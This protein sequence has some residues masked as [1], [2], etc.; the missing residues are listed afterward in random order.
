M[1]FKITKSTDWGHP[2]I[3]PC[4]SCREVEVSGVCAD[5]INIAKD[6]IWVRDI[7]TLEELLDFACNVQ[8]SIIITPED[9]NYWLKPT[10]P[11]IEIYND[12]RE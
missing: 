3:P 4:D 7:N 11:E 8:D 9:K 5:G 1:T 12:Y 6:K 10:F 2:N